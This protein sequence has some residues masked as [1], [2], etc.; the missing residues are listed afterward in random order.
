M[1]NVNGRTSKKGKE[2]C[3]RLDLKTDT[4]SPR[5]WKGKKLEQV[6]EEAIDQVY[7]VLQAAGKDGNQDV[8]FLRRYVRE[9]LKSSTKGRAVLDELG[10]G[11]HIEIPTEDGAK[12][13]RSANAVSV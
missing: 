13:K 7:Q 3:D 11:F 1:G 12:F 5:R 4:G 9:Q 6:D 2:I 10:E 8:Q